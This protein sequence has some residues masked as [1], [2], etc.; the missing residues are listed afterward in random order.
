[1]DRVFDGWGQP[2]VPTP[3]QNMMRNSFFSTEHKA[4]KL[5]D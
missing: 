2:G 3:T 4:T 1:M 5:F